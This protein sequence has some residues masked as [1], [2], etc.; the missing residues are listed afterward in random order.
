MVL[1]GI[2][3]EVAEVEHQALPGFFLCPH[4]LH[5]VQVLIH[6]AGSAV[7]LFDLFDEHAAEY[8]TGGR[9]CQDKI[10][11]CV[12]TSEYRLFS[13]FFCPPKGISAPAA[14]QI[15]GILVNLGYGIYMDTRLYGYAVQVPLRLR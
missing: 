10:S 5:Q 11:V 6:L 12:T 2:K 3:L 4:A 8:T 14:A 13:A 7:A 1:G 15:Q 9:S